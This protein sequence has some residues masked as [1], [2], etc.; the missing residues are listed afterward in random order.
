VSADTQ[1]RTPETPTSLQALQAVFT[2][3]SAHPH[4][5]A[6]AF[7]LKESSRPLESTDCTQTWQNGRLR[8]TSAQTDSAE[9]RV[10]MSVVTGPLQ[11]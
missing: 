11:S 8:R 4:G 6:L 3:G 7:A 10:A 5:S 2:V 1:T 9:V